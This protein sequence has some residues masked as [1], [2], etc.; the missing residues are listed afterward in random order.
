[1]RFDVLERVGIYG[2][3]FFFLGRRGKG[4]GRENMG[5]WIGKERLDGDER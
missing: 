2:W 4:N 1:M 3:G 5:R